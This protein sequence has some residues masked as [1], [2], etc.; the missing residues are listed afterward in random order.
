MPY[1]TS[2]TTGSAILHHPTLK[3]PIK[4][5]KATCAAFA[6]GERGL[7]PTSISL[8]DAANLRMHT[9]PRLLFSLFM[10]HSCIAS[11]FSSGRLFFYTLSTGLAFHA[12]KFAFADAHLVHLAETRGKITRKYHSRTHQLVS[13]AVMDLR[14]FCF[15]SLPSLITPDLRVLTKPFWFSSIP[16]ETLDRPDSG[17]TAGVIWG[18]TNTCRPLHS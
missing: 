3:E 6:K 12:G 7:H 15:T 16:S 5:A 10:L 8:T 14:I 9:M 4:A 1:K 11:L 2:S 17:R 18:R 13:V